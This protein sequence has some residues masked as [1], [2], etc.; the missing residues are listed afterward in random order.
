MPALPGGDNHDMWIDPTNGDRIA[1]ANDSGF[2]ISVNR[3]RTWNRVQLPI[4]QMYHV[5]VDNQIPYFV[6]GNKQDGT[7]VSRSQQQPGRRC[8]VRLRRRRRGPPSSRRGDGGGGGRPGRPISRS[9]WHQVTGGESGFATPDPVDPNIIWSSASGSGSVGGIVTVFDERNHQARNVEVWPEQ[10]SGSPAAE[11]KYR[12][13]WEFP[14]RSRRTTTSAS[15]WAAS[16]ST[17]P[18]MA[19]IAGRSSVPT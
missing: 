5:T 14:F 9:V 4:A 3:G 13:N 8:D 1:V 16:S 17:S 7:L 18:P 2:S 12:F 19:A 6:Y 10:T 15:T 11:L